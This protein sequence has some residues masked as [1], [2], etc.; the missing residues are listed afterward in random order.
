MLRKDNYRVHSLASAF[1]HDL[2][3]EYDALNDNMI[4]SKLHGPT[5][6]QA[7]LLKQRFEINQK[8]EERNKLAFWR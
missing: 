2:D 5:T 3:C 1:I 8:V 4:E 6:F 7:F